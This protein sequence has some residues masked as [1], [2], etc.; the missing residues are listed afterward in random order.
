MLKKIIAKPFLF[1]FGLVPLFLVIGFLKR[2]SFL[3]IN[4]DYIYF[5][6]NISLICNISAVFFLL[7]GFNYYSLFWAQKTPKKTLTIIHIVLQLLTIIPFLSVI[8]SFK[9]DGNIS[10]NFVSNNLILIVSFIVFL[11]SIFVHLINFFTS[12]FLKTE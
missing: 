10:T 11:L 2:D 3:N 12:L 4:V 6:I 9:I 1:F 8:L 7:I 5:D